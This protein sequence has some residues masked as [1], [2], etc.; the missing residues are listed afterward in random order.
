MKPTTH[1]PLTRL[2]GSAGG[3]EVL[4][5][6]AWAAVAVA[7]FATIDALSDWLEA[8]LAVLEARYETYCTRNSLRHS[9]A[10]GR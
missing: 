8:D 4:P 3:I 1:N 10:R 7:P 5:P 9:L 6:E 2:P